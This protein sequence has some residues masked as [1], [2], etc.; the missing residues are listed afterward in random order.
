MF[1]LKKRKLLRN[2]ESTYCRLRCS[3]GK[4]VGVFAVRYIPAG[5]DPFKGPAKRRWIKINV[6]EIGHLGP[7]VRQMTD[8]F[9]IIQPNG[10]V[11]IYEE[12]FNGLHIRWF[13]NHSKTPNLVTD[14]YALSFRT[15]RDIK[16]GEELCY[17]YGLCD[18]NWRN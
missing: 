10:D 9:C 11:R 3:E 7:A 6:E 16:A 8:D 2:L 5:T 1:G 4:G 12:G 14:D 15:V 13:V 18:S 17:D